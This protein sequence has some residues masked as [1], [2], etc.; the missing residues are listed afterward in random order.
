MSLRYGLYLRKEKLKRKIS[1][2]KTGSC[3]VLLYHRVRDT[4]YDPQ[5][6]SVSHAN[7]DAQ[8]EYLKKHYN[9]ITVETF[10]ERLRTQRPFKKNSLLI[11]FDDGYADNYHNALPILEKHSLQ[12]VFYIATRNLNSDEIFWWDELDEIFRDESLLNSSVL[13]ELLDLRKKSSATALYTFYLD[14]LKTAASLE[15]RDLLLGQVRRLRHLSKEEKEKHRCLKYS[16]LKNLSESSEAVIGAHTE[17][18][19]SLGHISHQDQEFEIKRSV[20]ELENLLGKSPTLFSYPYG[21]K[22]NY[23]EN[24]IR[25]CKELGLDHAAAN[26]LGYVDSAS[27][28]FSFPRFV[29]R[30]DDPETLHKKLKDIL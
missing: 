23:D 30:N 26:Y 24:C 22:H 6:L 5:L 19:L 11:T 9:F 12:S 15:A 25:I 29:V 18:H 20:V 8:L 13:K 17:N 10:N 4:N 3:I 16:E 21:E 28:L 2:L 1:R 7:F 14:H 27:D